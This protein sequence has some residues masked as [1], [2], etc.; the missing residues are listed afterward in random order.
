[1]ENV[2]FPVDIE[3]GGYRQISRENRLCP[4]CDVLED[5][6]HAIY[7]CVAYES[8]RNQ[9]KELL[10]DNPTVKK[11]LNP[12]DKDTATNVGT[13]LKLIEERRKGLV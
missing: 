8:I 5:E 12:Q 2:L 4:F 1:M 10:D 7:T 3:T 6:E 13:F 9:F 11:F